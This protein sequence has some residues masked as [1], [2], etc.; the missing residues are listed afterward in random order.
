MRRTSR[1]ER[2]RKRPP[3]KAPKIAP[4]ST[5]RAERDWTAI[6]AAVVAG[7]STRAAAAKFGVPY[8]TLQRRAAKEGW[9]KDRG[10]VEGEVRAKVD[11]ALTVD[12]VARAK[13]ANQDGDRVAGKL[14]AA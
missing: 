2:D 14:E 5:P 1:A 9:C 7:A 3:K 11:E 10:R 12:L 4:S 13:A 8:K 6:R